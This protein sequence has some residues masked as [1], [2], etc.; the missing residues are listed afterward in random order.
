MNLLLLFK[1]G[2]LCDS[3]DAFL[4]VQSKNPV[5]CM[6]LLVKN[7]EDILEQ[8]LIFHK[9]KGVDFFIVT[10]N[11]STDKTPE[12]LR[13]YQEKGWIKEIIEEKAT[14]YRQKVWVDRMVWRAKTVYKADG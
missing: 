10:D 4:L 3:R 2:S 7:E 6:T 5:V 9:Q 14:D 8:N 1:K 12:I 11:N 13:K